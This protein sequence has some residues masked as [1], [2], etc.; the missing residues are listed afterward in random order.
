MLDVAKIRSEAPQSGATPLGRSLPET[1]TIGGF[2]FAKDANETSRDQFG[3]AMLT[4]LLVLYPAAA[5]VAVVIAAFM[6][7]GSGG[8]V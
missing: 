2:G 4:M 6:L 1:R 3:R 8:V 5:S 7:S